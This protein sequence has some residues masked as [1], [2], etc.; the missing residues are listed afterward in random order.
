LYLSFVSVLSLRYGGEFN[1]FHD[2]LI[3]KLRDSLVTTIVVVTH[4]LAR[5]FTIG[6]NAVFLDASQQIISATVDPNQRMAE[7][8]DPVLR[9]YLIRGKN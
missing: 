5:I 8:R 2:D 3:L 4:E 1:Y 7:T 6:N 9:Q